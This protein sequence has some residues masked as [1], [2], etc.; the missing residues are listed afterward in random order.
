MTAP[1]WLSTR[2]C[3]SARAFDD[4]CHLPGEVKARMGLVAVC[5]DELHIP[6]RRQAGAERLLR[7]PDRLRLGQPRTGGHVEVRHEPVIDVDDVPARVEPDDHEGVSNR[8]AAVQL[9]EPQHRPADVIGAAR[10]RH[11]RQVRRQPEGAGVALKERMSR[12]VL[13]RRL[14]PEAPHHLVDQ[15]A[16]R[17]HLDSRPADAVSLQ[18]VDRPRRRGDRCRRQAQERPDDNEDPGPPGA[19]GASFACSSDLAK[20]EQVQAPGAEPLNRTD[21]R[22][23]GGDGHLSG[24]RAIGRESKA[25]TTATTNLHPTRDIPQ[26]PEAHPVPRPG[27]LRRWPARALLLRQD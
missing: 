27:N 3:Q 4:G 1:V 14:W 17:V 18:L 7:S 21:F 13:V 8:H 26:P 12:P 16:R 5:D 24:R 23:G 11:V 6:R 15:P 10:G 19:P 22:S 2:S 20:R 25:Q 9:S